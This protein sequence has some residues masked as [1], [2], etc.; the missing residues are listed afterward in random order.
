MLDEL[1]APLFQ[2]EWGKRAGL[3]MI[4]LMGLL[5]LWTFVHIVI[6]WHSDYVILRN[7]VTPTTQ[8]PHAAEDVTKWVTQIPER[9]LFGNPL[10]LDASALPI[11][12]LQLRL[13]GVIKSQPDSFSKV[14]ISEANQPGKVY[15]IGDT[16]PAGVTVY[17][18]GED[19]VVLENGG[20]LEKL[21]LPRPPLL[22]NGMPK[23]LLEKP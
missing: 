15:G 8:A 23:P 9:H 22:F 20:R 3:S 14:I 21:P 12:S 7:S 4:V 1:L 18:I 5:F 2:T 13:I 19:G 11:T 10:A 17:A 6:T 16:L